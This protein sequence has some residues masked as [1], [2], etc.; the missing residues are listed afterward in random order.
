MLLVVVVVVVKVHIITV[1]VCIH[2]WTVLEGHLACKKYFS[3]VYFCGVRGSFGEVG[4][5]EFGLKGTSRVCCGRHGKVGIVEFGLIAVQRVKVSVCVCQME[6]QLVGTWC[7]LRGM[8]ALPRR[9]CLH[10][11][12]SSSQ[13]SRT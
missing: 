13:R 3:E 1:Q 6:Q 12:Y 9:Q 10:S 11:A 2:A 4:V 8:S 7:A 5:M